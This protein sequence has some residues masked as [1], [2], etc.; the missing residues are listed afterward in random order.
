MKSD[1]SRKNKLLAVAAL[2]ASLFLV[3]LI[4]VQLGWLTQFDSAVT[5]WI[6]G[7]RQPLLTEV[8]L[9]ITTL[10][11]GEFLVLVCGGLCAW[12][13]SRERLFHWIVATAGGGAV[14]IEVLKIIVERLR[15]EIAPLYH[16]AGYSFP[17]GHAMLGAIV[18]G[19]LAYLVITMS[20]RSPYQWD[21]VALTVLIVGLIG[22]SRIYLGVHYPSDVAAG[23]FAGTAWLVVLITFKPK[24]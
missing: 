24:S 20:K 19:L 12:A 10:G 5:N 4:G 8:M 3:N 6:Y 17:S 2:F 18:Y 23:F 16:I 11:N 9:A 7:L 22:F 21:I 1:A 13:Y 14:L 15:P